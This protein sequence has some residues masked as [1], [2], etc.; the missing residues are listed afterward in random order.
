MSYSETFDN[1]V[2]VMNKQI[3]KSKIDSQHSLDVLVVDDDQDILFTVQKLLEHRGYSVAT[4]SHPDSII[5]K[6]KNLDPQLIILD[7]WMGDKRGTDICK[8]IKKDDALQKKP[9]VM[10]S[11]S[12]EIEKLSRKANADGY[13]KKPFKFNEL[14]SVV[15]RFGSFS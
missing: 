8:E 5:E 2:Q 1:F 3:N 7:I 6:V 4:E 14:L 13:I 9:V 15:T 12:D 10:F 11:S